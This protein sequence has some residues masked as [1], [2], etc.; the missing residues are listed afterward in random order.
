[1]AKQPEQA[2]EP[3]A[4]V[5][6]AQKLTLQYVDRPDL[7]ETFA[8][9]TGAMQFDGQTLRIEL[10]VTRFD[11]GQ[12]ASARRARRYPVSRLVLTPTAA[13]ELANRLQQTMAAAAQRRTARPGPGEN[14]PPRSDKKS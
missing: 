12:P 10:C 14:T 8:D 7:P 9:A 6:P 13:V 11:S 5:E 1:M 2:Q 4:A 3:R